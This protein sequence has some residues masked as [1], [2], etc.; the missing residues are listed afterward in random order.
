MPALTS[1]YAAAFYSR[2]LAILAL[3]LIIIAVAINPI[4]KKHESLWIFVMTSIATIPINTSLAIKYSRV[5]ML[6]YS[7]NIVGRV[8]LFLIIYSVLFSVEQ[9]TLGII[10]C[11][12]WKRQY[13]RGL[14]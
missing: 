12:I 8:V 13:E 10:G 11:L 7:D 1:G 5:L 2:G 6:L 3:F 9:T 14:V 4:C